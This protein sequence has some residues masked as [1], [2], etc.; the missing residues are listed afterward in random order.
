MVQAGEL[1]VLQSGGDD[2]PP[3]N[4]VRT[5][6][7]AVVI[8]AFVVGLGWLDLEDR[9]GE[10]ADLL[11]C[12]SR[13]EGALSGANG[14]IDNMSRYVAPA[15]ASSPAADV[16]D[17]LRALIR[18]AAAK[19]TPAVAGALAACDDV[20]VRTWH[21]GVDRARDRYRTYLAA[22]LQLLQATVVDDHELFV[23]HPEID[24]LQDEARAALLAVAP[25]ASDVDAV[26]PDRSR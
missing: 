9:R 3:R 19:G 4:R 17:G 18:D 13:G 14:A 11:G 15:L 12:V 2:R 16:T 20:P 7:V 26:L 1:E 10:V 8:A 24:G 6:A 25:R 22:R 21:G 5:A 23:R